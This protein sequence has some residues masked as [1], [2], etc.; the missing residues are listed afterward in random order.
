MQKL[1]N[2]VN[3][4]IVP[5]RSDA[6]LKVIDPSTG[7]QYAQVADSEGRDVD[8][9]VGAA[10][11]AFTTWSSMPVAERSQHLF[12]LADLIDERTEELAA[13]ESRD[14]GKTITQAR[15]LEIPR[16]AS[17]FRFFAGAIM[18]TDSSAHFT[19][20]QAIN[21]TVHHPIGVAGCISPWNLPLYLFTWKIAPALCTGNTVVAK[22]S[23]ITP[24]TAYML[25]E[26]A[27]EAGLP[28][29]V[30]NIVHGLGS[31]VGQAIVE[32]PDIP[33]ISFTGGTRTGS[34]IARSA[35]PLFKKL[36]L[37]LG[38]KNPSVV[39]ADSNFEHAVE[40]CIRSAFS[41]QGEICLCGSRI[42]VEASIYDAFVDA[43]V[44]RAD[45]L[46]VG[47]PLDPSSNMGAIVSDDHL[48]KIRSYIDLAVEEGGKVLCGGEAPRDLPERCAKGCFLRPTVITGLPNDCRT[49]Q[50]EIF[51]PVVTI[52]P[53]TDEPE[54][55]SLANQTPYGLAASLF[56]SNLQR[57]HRVAAMLEVG[58]V[59]INCWLL[60]DLRV[61]FGGM[62]A[63]GVGREGGE[64]AIR[65]F[66]EPKNV[67]V[68]LG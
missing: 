4:R 25:S 26:L 61:P 22:P 42:L 35:G 1:G 28:D 51:G 23:E 39:F 19:D 10:A 48:A 63:S 54:A 68:A 27:I 18:H 41:T 49:N 21:Y 36:S 29:G 44:A 8:D 45:S 62:K 9:A 40:T 16:A 59:W 56:T 2:L 57:A 50:E 37:E 7:N 6:W 46:V 47:D 34:S 31:K 32:H 65:F 11:A 43:F 12:R 30:L 3:G 66:T 38:G 60:R 13:A 17:N 33:A 58:T 64:E 67:C 14:N 24:M 52:M 15:T 20:E 5:P 53:F 55:I